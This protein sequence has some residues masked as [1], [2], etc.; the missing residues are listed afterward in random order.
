ME[1]RILTIRAGKGDRDRRAILPETL[2]Q[3]LAEAIEASLAQHG[4]DIE[5]GAGW[6]E[7]PAALERKYQNAARSPTMIYTHVLNRGPFGVRSP[8]DRLGG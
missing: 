5:R 7:L 6:V 1:S 4:R 3:A 2:R 8:A